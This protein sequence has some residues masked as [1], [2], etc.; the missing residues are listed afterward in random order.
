M[1]QH[2]RQHHRRQ[3]RKRLQHQLLRLPPCRSSQETTAPAPAAGQ[4]APP[5]IMPGAIRASS[6]PGCGPTL[7]GSRVMTIRKNHSGPAM[8]APWR[9][10]RAARTKTPHHSP[11]PAGQRQAAGGI[12][13]PGSG[14]WSENDH[15]PPCAVCAATIP[16]GEARH[17]V[18]VNGGERF[19]EH[20]QRGAGQPQADQRTQRC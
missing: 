16:P 15:P 1:G 8:S 2:L 18:N 20:P 17:A 3:R 10:P 9:T 13:G 7:N 6:L 4:L 19:V 5:R 12:R 11:A 14:W